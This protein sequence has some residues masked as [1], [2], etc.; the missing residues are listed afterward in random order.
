[1]SFVDI[2]NDREKAI[3]I[4]VLIL[5]VWCFAQKSV[6]ENVRAPFFSLLKILFVGK[7]GVGLFAMVSYVSLIVFLFY[8]VH[9]WDISLLK[10]TIYWFL[11]AA[12]IMFI[13]ISKV[14]EKSGYFKN[15]LLDNLKF[16][17]ILEFIIN[18][19]VFNIFIELILVPLI[20]VIIAMITFSDKK[21]EYAQVKKILSAL[22]SIIGL[23]L[24]FFA[25]IHVFGDF[26]DFATVQNAK[27]FLLPLVL[28]VT[29][30]P[31]IYLLA[32][33]ATYD[34]FFVRVDI[35]LKE[36]KKLARYTKWQIFRVCHINLKKLNKFSKKSSLELMSI[37]NRSDVTRLIRQF[38]KG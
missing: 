21:K 15:V 2:F 22:L 12:F 3:I 30:L 24:L 23:C 31:F 35:W 6:R 26:K 18:L 13:N 34:S 8:I 9:L 4:W 1:M 5:L 33:Y 7:I 11:G 16:S 29:F 28:T 19:Y 38:K 17:I 25:F 27:S 32:L 20:S 14:T 36:N 37:K 10:D